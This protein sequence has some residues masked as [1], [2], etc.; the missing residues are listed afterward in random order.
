[1]APVQI[2]V[3]AFYVRSSTPI[4]GLL[5]LPPESPRVSVHIGNEHPGRGPGHLA[6]LPRSYTLPVLI[7]PTTGPEE[8]QPV[9]L[10]WVCTANAVNALFCLSFVVCDA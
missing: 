1:M 7:L 8:T 4:L 2:L 5:P 3:S 9:L 6:L 10:W